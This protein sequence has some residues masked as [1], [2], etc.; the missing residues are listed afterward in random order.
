[1][2]AVTVESP[3]ELARLEAIA[4]RRGRRTPVLLRM[5]V[6][7]GSPPEPVRIVGDAGAGKFGMVDIRA[8]RPLP[9]TIALAMARVAGG[10]LF[11]ISPH[12]P[13]TYVALAAV[14]IVPAVAAAYVPARRASRLDPLA[15]LR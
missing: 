1:M 12:D 10:L 14:L 11:G 9:R 15:A 3:G 4:A 5:A 13:S 7:V 6:G 2:R 8:V